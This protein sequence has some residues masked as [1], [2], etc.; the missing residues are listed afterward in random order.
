[1][2]R[3]HRLSHWDWT[4]REKLAGTPERN[5]SIAFGVGSRQ[6]ASQNC[7]AKWVRMVRS[8]IGPCSPHED[9]TVDVEG[10]ASDDGGLVTGQIDGHRCDFFRFQSASERGHGSL[11]FCDGLT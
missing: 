8:T 2:V 11:I 9:P 5:G 6:K 1:M 7:S 10:L 3:F 4:G